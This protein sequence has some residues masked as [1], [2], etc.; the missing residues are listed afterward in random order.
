[1][2]ELKGTF[3]EDPAP[4]AGG[5][6]TSNIARTSELKRLRDGPQDIV[7]PGTYSFGGVRRVVY[8]T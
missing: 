8:G 3:G 1:M 6:N 2:G 5:M 4:L 7:S